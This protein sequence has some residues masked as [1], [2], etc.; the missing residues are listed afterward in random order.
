MDKDKEVQLDK[1]KDV[2]LDKDKDVQ[3]DNAIQ[4]TFCCSSSNK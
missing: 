3:G 2:Q 1:D 4:L